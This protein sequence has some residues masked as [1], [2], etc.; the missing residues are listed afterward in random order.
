MVNLFGP[1]PTVSERELV[2]LVL[3]RLDP[4]ERVSLR[5]SKVGIW[6]MREIDEEGIGRLIHETWERLRH[7]QRQ[8][9]SLT[10]DAIDSREALGAGTPEPGGLTHREAHPIMEVVASS[11]TGGSADV[12]EIHP[13]LDSQNRTAHIAVEFVA[14]LLG[15]SILWAGICTRCRPLHCGSRAF[16]LHPGTRAR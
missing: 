4:D 16:V 2:V 12:V 15:A 9:V 7:C 14:C 13:I 1:G 5:S 11:A 8:L 3:R 6:M 10:M